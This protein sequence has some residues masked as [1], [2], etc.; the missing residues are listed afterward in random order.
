MCSRC[1]IEDVYRNV[2]DFTD[3]LSEEEQESFKQNQDVLEIGLDSLAAAMNEELSPEAT[4][5]EEDD[6]DELLQFLHEDAAEVILPKAYAGENQ[7]VHS[8]NDEAVIVTLDGSQS[9]DPQDRIE[10]WSWLDETGREISI[11]PKVRVK[12]SPGNHRFELRV[13]DS[14][15]GMTSDSIQITIESSDS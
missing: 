11:E 9:S 15:G 6:L 12:L 3:L 10:A 1:Y 8:Q 5:A 7:S 14:E 13:F 4:K 2:D